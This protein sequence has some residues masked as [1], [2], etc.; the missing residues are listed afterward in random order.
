MSDKRYNGWANYETWLLKLWMDND[1]GSDQYYRELAQEVYDA[2]VATRSFTRDEQAQLDLADR[3][4]EEYENAQS[5][6]AGV[7]GF[8]SDLLSAAMS[9]VNW[10]EIAEHMIADV[11]KDETAP[12][13]E[14]DL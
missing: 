14:D 1:Q 2:A 9:E 11:D 10:Q 12:D 8:W 5:E 4:K 6:L 7:T 3:I 13:S